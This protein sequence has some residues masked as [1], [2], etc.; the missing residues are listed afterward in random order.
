MIDNDAALAFLLKKKVMKLAKI[1]KR[2][3]LTITSPP[4]AALLNHKRL[5]RKVRQKLLRRKESRKISDETRHKL[6]VNADRLFLN[7]LEFAGLRVMIDLFRVT[8]LAW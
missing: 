8:R 1:T 4:L 7:T 5:N 3:K 6:F 2:K